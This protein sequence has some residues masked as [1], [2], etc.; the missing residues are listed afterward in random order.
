L[1]NAERGIR[2]STGFFN[3]WLKKNLILLSTYLKQFSFGLF[4]FQWINSVGV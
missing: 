2:A 4:V 3:S 1:E